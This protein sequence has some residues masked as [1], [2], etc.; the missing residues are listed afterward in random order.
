MVNE[1]DYL[2]T[3]KVRYT[4]WSGGQR[5][6]VKPTLLKD[7]QS[8]ILKDVVLDQLGTL[9][10]CPG[11]PAQ[12]ATPKTDK[13]DGIGYYEKSTGKAYLLVAIG[14]KLYYDDLSVTPSVLVEIVGTFSASSLWD[15]TV[16]N[17][18]VFIANGLDPLKTWD[19]ITLTQLATAQLETATVIGTITTAGNATVVVT[20]A[21]M[22]GSPKTV[23]VPVALADT[24]TLV[25]GKITNALKAD[26][27]INSFFYVSNAG[28]AIAVS[29]VL[30]IADDATMNISIANGTCAGLT[31]APTSVN[32]RAGAAGIPYTFSHLEV[33]TNML[34]GIEARTSRLRWSAILDG[35]TWDALHFMDFNSLD[36]D[37]IRR[38]IRFTSYLF[39]AKRRSKAYVTGDTTANYAYTWLEGNGATGQ[40]SVDI[41][42]KY[43]TYIS[44]D[45]IH[46]TDLTT[47]TLI[48][49][50]YNEA[51]RTRVNKNA[52]DKAALIHWRNYVVVSLP[53]DGSSVNNE[54]WIY[55]MRYRAW[56]TLTKLNISCFTR[57]Y[58]NGD[59]VLYGGDS[60]TGQVVQLLK[61]GYLYY[62]D[63]VN[64]IEYQCLS[65][66]WTHGEPERYKL[67]KN[68]YL[69]MEGV[70]ELSRVNMWMYVDDVEYEVS[71]EAIDVPDGAGLYRHVRL[72]PPVYGAVLG[73]KLSVR[74]QGRV[75]IRSITVEYALRSNVPPG[76]VI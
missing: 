43:V 65:K 76:G 2:K 71:T 62:Q 24:A 23:S 75:G 72:I 21:G 74:L 8:Q 36:G 32:T 18:K 40:N 57:A 4:D 30:A 13:V 52:L 26:A 19:G 9:Y 59:E 60:T 42:E 46:M 50:A 68:I 54:V 58:L 35:S 22:T 7:N 31:A 5:D 28:P 15:F 69:E 44:A 61:T 73:R 34:W 37:T 16:F 63:G 51:W 53:V 27:V 47:D 3:Y 38:M 12:Y 29:P 17:D 41:A 14:T 10:P 48:S 6:E 20:A 33:H 67:Y 49:T 25:A 45:G 66:E 55:D 11:H 39:V 56:I 64:L 1:N 70:E